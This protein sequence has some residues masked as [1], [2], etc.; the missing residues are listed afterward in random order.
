VIK[1]GKIN[2]KDKM[3][4]IKIWEITSNLVMRDEIIL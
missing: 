1:I 2:K 4:I 3:I